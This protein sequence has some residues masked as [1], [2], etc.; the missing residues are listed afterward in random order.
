MKLLDPKLDI[1]FKLLFANAK[2]RDILISLLTAVLKPSASIGTVEVLNPEIP[3][4]LSADK[5]IVLD[6]H[7]R[8]AD[9]RHIDVE[10]QS[11]VHNA[12]ISRFL[13]YWAR[14]HAMQLTVGH[15]YEKL[16]PTVS[17]IILKESLLPIAKAHSKFRVLETET[18]HE[19]TD[20]LDIHF[21]ELPKIALGHDD[22]ALAS[23]MRF[24]LA[25]NE[26]ELEEV[27][28]SDPNIRRAADALKVLSEDPA[29]Q[30]LAREREL[31][32]INLKIMRQF[33]YE[34][35]EARG[36]A[37]GRVEGQ[38]SLLV[39]Q[40]ARKFGQ[41]PPEVQ[42]RLQAASSVEI[43]HWADRVLVANSLD[44]VFAG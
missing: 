35:G 25:G 4:D 10:M 39:R 7:V 15:H 8:L 24:L 40:I 12:L 19:L 27:A 32:Q 34:A 30:E 44:E 31:G 6:I 17:V 18:G 33:E 37:E 14:L 9:G 21:V 38:A 20:D 16:C 1:V 42:A 3:K 43:E 26:E 22:T 41:V 2:N 36:R 28:M 13:Y 11:Q 29:A 23:W 5:G